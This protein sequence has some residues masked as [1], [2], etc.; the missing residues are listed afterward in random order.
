[1]EL[2]SQQH[3]TVSCLVLGRLVAG[4][5]SRRTGFAPKVVHVGY[6]V[7]EVALE[8]VFLWNLRFS[9]VIIIPRPRHIEPRIIWQ[10]Y[11]V[12]VTAALPQRQSPPV[13]T[14]TSNL[15]V[16]RLN[17]VHSLTSCFFNVHF[18]F[19]FPP[20][21]MSLKWFLKL[22]F[23]AKM[24]CSSHRPMY[25]ACSACLLLTD[26]A[27]IFWT[28][29]LWSFKICNFLHH[30]SLRCKYFFLRFVVK[31]PQYVPVLFAYVESPCLKPA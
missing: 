22:G 23:P 27:N 26:Q 8:Q 12:L 6:A 24:L 5:S 10:M 25:A 1:M 20:T 17:P 14:K 18:Y 3:A 2:C 28:E 21:L 11:G 29:K 15:I 13:V 16:S 31:H 9:P 4:F 7:G 19:F 30:C